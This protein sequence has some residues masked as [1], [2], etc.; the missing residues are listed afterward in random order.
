VNVRRRFAWFPFTVTSGKRIWL[1]WYYEH[2]QYH[3]PGTGKPPAVGGCFVWTETPYEQ[4]I[5][6]L[7][8]D[9]N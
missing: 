1:S 2:F 6:L 7:Q 3:D 9:Y 5:R 4:I 8:K